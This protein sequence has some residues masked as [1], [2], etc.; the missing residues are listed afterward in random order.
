MFSQAS[1]ILFTGGLVADTPIGKTPPL[2][3][4][5]PSRHTPRQTH[6]QADRPLGQTPPEQTPPT[7]R[8]HT[9]W[10]DTPLRRNASYWNAFLFL[11][12]SKNFL[13]KS[14]TKNFFIDDHYKTIYGL[15]RSERSSGMVVKVRQC[16]PKCPEKKPTFFREQ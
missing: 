9:P 16:F 15:V 8:R 11:K 13:S 12:F 1:V 4:Y 14:T 10:A 3:R 5:R 6:T 2:G 7:L